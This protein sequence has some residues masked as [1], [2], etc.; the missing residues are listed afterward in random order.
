VA[1]SYQYLDSIGR[2][3]MSLDGREVFK[4]RTPV[5]A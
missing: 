3:T 1:F 5:A 2:S 4:A